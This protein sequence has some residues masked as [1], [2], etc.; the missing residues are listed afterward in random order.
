ML[1]PQRR[2]Q[3]DVVIRGKQS[4]SGVL[5]PERRRQ[6][7]LALEKKTLGGFAENVVKS[8]GRA[9]G[10]LTRAITSPIQTGKSLLGLGAGVVQKFIPGE[11]KQEKYADAVGQSYKDRYGTPKEWLSGNFSKAGNTLYNDPVGAGLDVATIAGVGG[12]ALTKGAKL[13]SR[14]ERAVSLSSPISKIGKAGSTLTKIDRATDPL[15]I[16]GRAV[17]KVAKPVARATKI[18]TS[19]VGD[20]LG[21]KAQKFNRTNIEKIEQATKMKPLEYARSKNLPISATEKSVQKVEDILGGSQKKFNTLTKTDTKIDRNLL[22]KE[23]E[24][25][26]DELSRGTRQE[27]SISKTLLD[28]AEYHR[29]HIKEP[30]TDT[31]L[32]RQITKSFNESSAQQIADPMKSGISEQFARSGQKARE[33]IHPGATEAGRELR[34]LRTY[35]DELSKQASTGKGTQFFNLFKPA[36][37]GFLAGAG[38]GSFLPGIGNIGGALIGG[39]AT[40]IANSPQFLEFASNMLNSVSKAK[41]VTMPVAYSNLFK[42]AYSYSKAGRVFTPTSQE[43]QLIESL[44]QLQESPYKDNNTDPFKKYP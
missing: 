37:A 36:G 35:M 13:A 14:G 2:Q 12:S 19:K 30:L 41:G 9:I 24:S 32:T 3:M 18:G 28:E 1:T 33:T 21:S 22:I 4:Q 15:Q 7:D 20:F 39:T 43:A 42:K 11:Q 23:I 10:D 17:S 40:A 29:K 31:E 16:A 8:G 27:R 34:G 26:A 25:K 38:A 44:Q 5:T 6:M